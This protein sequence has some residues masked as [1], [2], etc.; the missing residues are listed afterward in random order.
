VNLFATVLTKK[1]PCANYRGESE[2]NRAVIQKVTDGRFEFPIFSPESMRNALREILRR[3]ELP[4]NRER[5]HD[6]KQL[7]VKF[8]DLPHPEKYADDFFFGYL[9]AASDSNRLE[10]KQKVILNEQDGR[11]AELRA[12]VSDLVTVLSAISCNGACFQAG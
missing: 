2:L 3:Y 12:G 9:V 4:S 6:E 10:Y 1:Q 5:L 8:T 11:G 7:A